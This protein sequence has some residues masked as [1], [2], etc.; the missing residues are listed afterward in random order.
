MR[1]RHVLPEGTRI[2]DGIWV[3]TFTEAATD[4]PTPALFL[5]RDGTLVEEVGFLSRSEDLRLIEGAVAV[6][7]AANARRIRVVIVSNQ[8]GIGRALF[9]WDD[10]AAVQCRLVSAL[11][12]GGAFLDAVFACPYHPQA[13]APY[14]HPDHPDRKPNPGMILRACALLTLDLSRSWIIGDR[15]SDVIAGRRAGL[16][17]ALLVTTGFGHVAEE[18]EAALREQDREDF[19]VL[20]G[21]SIA[22]ALADVP[23]LGGEDV[24]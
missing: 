3:Q 8:S 20:L 14:D 6:I 22:A 9:G 21:P 18:Q 11:A 4:S 12:E 19:R 7:A 13:R 2:D 24:A 1:L 15:A 10:F 5:D 23:L 17:G 16:A